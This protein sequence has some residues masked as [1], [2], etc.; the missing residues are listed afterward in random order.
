M[1]RRRPSLIKRLGKT[2][3]REHGQLKWYIRG[4]SLETPKDEKPI[5][6][7]LHKVRGGKR[8]L[9]VT[10]SIDRHALA[11]A[12]P[13]LIRRLWPLGVWVGRHEYFSIQAEGEEHPTVVRKRRYPF[14]G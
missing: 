3:P 7:W 12:D 2:I 4:R 5:I 14:R 1:Q 8:Y 9:I 11:A 13:K 10:E 6:D